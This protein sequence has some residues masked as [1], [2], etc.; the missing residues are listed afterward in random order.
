M[1]AGGAVAA[2]AFGASAGDTCDGE[3][4]TAGAHAS[5]GSRDAAAGSDTDARASTGARTGTG[6]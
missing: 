3:S 4:R 1:V 6:T 5:P 2:H